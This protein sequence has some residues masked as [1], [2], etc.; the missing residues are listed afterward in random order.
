MTLSHGRLFVKL[1]K[2]SGSNAD[3]GSSDTERWEGLSHHLLGAGSLAGDDHSRPR[4]MHGIVPGHAC[5]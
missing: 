5:E 4:R 2:L 3:D 1:V